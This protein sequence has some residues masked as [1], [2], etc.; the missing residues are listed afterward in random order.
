MNRL[1]EL[2]QKKKD[3][4]ITPEEQAELLKLSKGKGNRRS[5][6]DYKHTQGKGKGYSSS[7]VDFGPGNDFSWWNKYPELIADAANFKC[8]YVAGKSIAGSDLPYVVPGVLAVDLEPTY[9][10]DIEVTDPINIW[11]RDLYLKMFQKYRPASGYTASDLG[12]AIIAGIECLKL[13]ASYERIYGVVNRYSVRNINMPDAEAASLGLTPTQAQYLRGHLSDFRYDLNSLLMKAQRLCIPKD[14]S[15]IADAISLFGYEYMDHEN[16]RAQFINFRL[17]HCGLYSDNFMQSGGCVVM[18]SILYFD[19]SLDNM[20]A[21]LDARLNALLGSDSIQRIYA[22]LVVWFGEGAM[23]QFLPVPENFTVL[24][25][26]SEE[27]LHKLHNMEQIMDFGASDTFVSAIDNAL[28]TSDITLLGLPT[29]GRLI[30]Q[31]DDRIVSKFGVTNTNGT[32]TVFTMGGV[33]WL[34]STVSSVASINKAHP[35]DTYRNDVTPDIVVEGVL[36]K[37][38]ANSQN[39]GTNYIKV[40]ESAAF[41][42]VVRVGLITMVGGNPTYTNIDLT[43][44]SSL[45]NAAEAAGRLAVLDWAPLV[46]KLDSSLA[47]EWIGGDVDNIIPVYSNDIARLQRASLLSGLRTDQ[48]IVSK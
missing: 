27:I 7:K 41:Y 19:F 28:P 1:Q 38:A 48:P 43:W 2:L 10:S 8:N 31:C 29:T 21:A 30:Y 36:F 25:T 37:H 44:T 35:L 18:E 23:M 15:A 45:S 16:E 17:R 6:R 11:A 14:I 20:C 42:V 3:G 4:T 13:I 32:R 40:V 5:K 12:I 33:Q 34:G 46:I 26:Y 24:P 47:V 22:D 39:D 9:G